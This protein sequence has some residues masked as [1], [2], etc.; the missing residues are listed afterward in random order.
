MILHAPIIILD[1]PSCTVSSA[2]EAL[3]VLNWTPLGIRR[4]KHRCISI[5]VYFLCINGRIDFDFKLTTINSI[6]SHN[7]RTSKNLHL[8]KANTNWGKQKPTY[9][10]SKDFNNLDNTIKNTNSL[11]KI[12][13]FSVMCRGTTQQVRSQSQ[14][15]ERFIEVKHNLIPRKELRHL[16]ISV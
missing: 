15:R 10:A 6:H 13:D 1:D 9:Q 3:K 16:L 5:F 14:S 2:T 4:H 11:N 8:P 7:T 12:Q